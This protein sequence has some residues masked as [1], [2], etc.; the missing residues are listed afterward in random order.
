[1]SIGASRTV[2][3]DIAVAILAT[4]MFLGYKTNFNV[5][6]FDEGLALYGSLRVASGDLPYRDFWTTYAP[7]SYYLGAFAFHIAGASAGVMRNVWLILQMLI[8]IE[9]LLLARKLGGRISGWLALALAVAVTIQGNLSSGYSAVPSLAAALGALI[10]FTFGRSAFVSGLFVGLTAVF[11]HDFGG[12]LAIALVIGMLVLAVF[13][14]RQPILDLLR[15]ASGTMLV[16]LPVYGLL[17]WKAGVHTIVDQLIRFPASA[18]STYYSLPW[19]SGL[20]WFIVP[21]LT[22]SAA[23][24]IAVSGV[25]RNRS[26]PRNHTAIVVLTLCMFALGLFNYGVI[27]LDRIHSWPMTI[28]VVPLIAAAPFIPTS[29]NRR[30]RLAVVVGSVVG[31]YGMLAVFTLVAKAQIPV[32]ALVPPRGAGVTIP[33]GSASYN[34]LIRATRAHT[35]VDEPIFSGA[36]R[37]DQVL[38][39]DVLLYFLTER[40]AP[41]PYYELNRGLMADKAV[42]TEIIRTLEERRVRVIVL[43]DKISDE[44]NKSSVPNGIPLLDN[45]IRQHYKPVGTFGDYHLMTR[46]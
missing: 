15:F 32:V 31:V 29:V 40:S 27:R 14:Q 33:V 42:H 43:L 38:I 12:Y 6:I 3:V 11:R 37:H 30:R 7:G 34:D 10:A 35:R 8:A 1:M 20:R 4:Y 24:L 36:I 21:I 39:T 44:P 45:Y 19:V 28:T 41:T 18:L 26:F 2:C 13:H 9:T 22:L 46:Q 16:A 5:K 25:A 17:A 23:S